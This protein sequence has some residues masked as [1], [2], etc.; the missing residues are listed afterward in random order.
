MKL[1]KVK[2]TDF[3]SIQDSNEFDIGDVTCLVGKN[4]AGKTALLKALYR[5]NPVLEEDGDFDVT[6]DYPRQH[7]TEYEEA[8][9]HG[10]SHANVVQATFALEDED[11]I[12]VEERFGPDC[13]VGNPPTATLTKGYANR[14]HINNLETDPEA[15][16]K[17]LI[18]TA[19]LPESMNSSL[20][21]STSFEDALNRLGQ[22]DDTGTHH[23]LTTLLTAVTDKGLSNYIWNNILRNNL[24]KFLYFDEYFQMT[25]RENIDQ[26][27][28]RQDN[29]QLED[30]DHPLLG[31]IDLAR[32][33]L[34]EM[35]NPQRT[36]RVMAMLEAA[37]NS[38]TQRVLPY[39][40][41][42]RH[43]R[44]R[45]DVRPGQP[46]DP[47][48]MTSGTN[49]WGRVEDTR[50]FVS[51]SLGTRSRGF[52]W[53]F[54]FLAW[55]HRVRQQ[56]DNLI[57]LLD[58]PGLFL[59]GKA[60]GDLL[61]YIEKELKPE[62]Q[63]IYTTHSPFMVDSTR[64]DRVRI[65][66]D[67][68]I[69]PLGAGEILSEDEQGTKVFEDVLLAHQDS[70]FP[71]QGALGYEI[72]Q[73]LF[74]GPN[75]LVVEGVSDLLYIQTISG[76]L[77]QRGKPGLS[78]QWTITPVGGS[79]KVSTF[80]ALLG[81]QGN[82]NLATLIDFQKKDQQNI[83]N[84]YKSKLLSKANVLTFD[85]FVMS[86]EADIEDMFDVDFYLKILNAEFNT[87]IQE[88]DLVSQHPRVLVRIENYIEGNP[89]PN[90]APLNHY[91][92][93]RY[94]AEN[95]GQL[96]SDIHDSVLGRFQKAF[97]ALNALL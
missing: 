61:R 25:G 64:F 8:V 83:E 35:V 40:S 62:H 12:P 42:N 68:S 22:I 7:V 97:D 47:E 3:Q 37:S 88:N 67:R 23:E 36:E 53:F 79:D 28:W 18:E 2:I 90:S 11:V 71:L 84:L 73:T 95:I 32:I 86:S 59:H 85:Q 30:S 70:L 19:D 27:Q 5:L 78:P 82:L 55:Y 6:D 58:E 91:R 10:K 13:L 45:F 50:H 76:L 48:G 15:A 60:Q 75:C 87:N 51:T 31:L 72:H 43:L 46:G 92:P 69:E 29:N 21:A 66:Q 52:I 65:V 74:V 14:R 80:V 24:P 39:W 94:F 41:Q 38:L 57:L 9:E 34:T 96:E 44:L 93:A 20:L 54:S 89:L 16:L 49:I 81:A 17:H 77:Q 4:E 1:V 56:N 33:N 63:V 26:L